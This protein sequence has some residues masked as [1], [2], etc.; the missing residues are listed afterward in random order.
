MEPITLTVLGYVI[1]IKIVGKLALVSVCGRQ[2]F[3]WKFDLLK[4]TV[5][6]IVRLVLTR[7]ARRR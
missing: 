1:T 5:R 4:Y 6:Q 2:C 3:K 7:L